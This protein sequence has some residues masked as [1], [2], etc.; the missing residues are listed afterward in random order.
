M[1]PHA[2]LQP[3]AFLLNRCVASQSN[4]DTCFQPSQLWV[5]ISSMVA[6]FSLPGVDGGLGDANLSGF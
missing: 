2:I 5:G 4:F 1:L 6:V 3:F